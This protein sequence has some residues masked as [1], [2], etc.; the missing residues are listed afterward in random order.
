MSCPSCGSED[1]RVVE[2]TC[3]DTEWDEPNGEVLAFSVC[4]NCDY[5]INDHTEG[6]CNC[7]KVAP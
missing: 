7:A 5:G 6:E 4:A 1:V 3:P 2:T